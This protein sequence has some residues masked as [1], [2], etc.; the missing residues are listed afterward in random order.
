MALKHIAVRLH[1]VV[2]P[3]KGLPTEF[4]H[5]L[6]YEAWTPNLEDEY[7]MLVGDI[8]SYMAAKLKQHVILLE[9]KSKRKVWSIKPE[10]E[11]PDEEEPPKPKSKRGRKK[12]AA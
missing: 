8:R 7:K 9:A 6:G 4:D 3:D 5:T 1:V 10:A 2:R 12:K 11:E